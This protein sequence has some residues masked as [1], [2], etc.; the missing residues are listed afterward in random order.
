MLTPFPV[1]PPESP[2]NIL[3]SLLLWGY[4][5]TH[6]S[7]QAHWSW[8]SPT[9]EHWFFTE[10][11]AS[12]PIDVLQDYHLLYMQLEPWFPPCVIF[13]W[14]FSPWE[15]GD[16]GC[17][18]FLFFLWSRKP[19]QVLQSF[20]YLIHWGPHAQS[21]GCCKHLPLYLSGSGRAFQETAIS[22]SC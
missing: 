5:P 11:R 22:D 3:P 4:S 1:S 17:L 2:Y 8:H 18:I 7:T 21:N 14:W 15:I 6:P 10:P 12:P 16:S 19:V 20:L 9:L 13:S